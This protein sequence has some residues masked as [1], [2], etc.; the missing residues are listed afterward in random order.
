LQK[1][2]LP[3]TAVLIAPNPQRSPP[4]PVLTGLDVAQVCWCDQRRYHYAEPGINI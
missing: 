4:F 3:I 2:Q 1:L